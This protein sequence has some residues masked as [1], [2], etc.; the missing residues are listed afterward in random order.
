[1]PHGRHVYDKSSDMPK[2]TMCTYP[3]YDH[4]FP[5]YKCVFWCFADCPCI[6]LP[7]RETN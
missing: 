5:H 6:N 2:A 4:A 1:M 3:Q 7:D